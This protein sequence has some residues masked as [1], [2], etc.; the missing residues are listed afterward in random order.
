MARLK[1]PVFHQIVLGRDPNADQLRLYNKFPNFRGISDA[2]RDVKIA[3]AVILLGLRSGTVDSTVLV[4]APQAMEE[5][6]LQQCDV[7]ATSCFES[8]RRYEAQ[9]AKELIDGYTRLFQKLKMTSRPLQLSE[10]PAHW[11]SF[12]FTREDVLPAWMTP[13]LLNVAE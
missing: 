6:F 11:V 9:R 10:E 3:E 4:F 1:T 12:G 13:R 8:C 2:Q 7:M 5:W